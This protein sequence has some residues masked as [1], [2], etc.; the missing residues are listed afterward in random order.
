M[1]IPFCEDCKT[2]INSKHESR[3]LA[4][5]GTHRMG[6]RSVPK[7]TL[8]P[9]D[10]EMAKYSKVLHFC[11]FD[12]RAAFVEEWSAR[13]MLPECPICGTKLPAD[14]RCPNEAKHAADPV[15][16]EVTDLPN[17]EERQSARAAGIEAVEQEHR[18]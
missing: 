16:G 14:L 10:D 7:L 4:F 17:A 3:C 8:H 13:A 9:W 11:S 5:E 2:A 6:K 12:C 18:A 1:L 15:V